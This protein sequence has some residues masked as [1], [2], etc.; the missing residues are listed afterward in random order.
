MSTFP[1]A[2]TGTM[3]PVV[4]EG[5]SQYP[6][7]PLAR[8]RELIVATGAIDIAALDFLNSSARPEQT[9]VGGTPYLI[10]ED[11]SMFVIKPDPTALLGLKFALGHTDGSDPNNKQ[12]L[13]AVVGW[14]ELRLKNYPPQWVGSVIADGYI[15]A[16]DS[17]ITTGGSHLLP[18][19]STSTSNPTNYDFNW[20]DTI[21]VS[22]DYSIGD[23]CKV[24]NDSANGSAMLWLDF[25]SCPVVSV[26]L[27]CRTSTPPGLTACGAA[28][29]CWT[30]M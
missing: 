14:R 18:P 25:M 22:N 23:A 21:V 11:P 13:F 8:N 6:F 28:T 12:A 26:V 10:D 20:A 9:D 24:S 5:S 16:G 1:N 2:K 15:V 17:T 19:G 7:M 30:Q 27:S 3:I 29:G 4:G